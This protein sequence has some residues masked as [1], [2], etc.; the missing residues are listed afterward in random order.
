[1]DHFACF[2]DV[3]SSIREVQTGQKR[4][5][6]LSSFARFR[7]SFLIHI[8]LAI[9]PSHSFGYTLFS[10]HNAVVPSSFDRLFGGGICQP[11]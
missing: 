4:R 10:G 1:M 8:L 9:L 3:C 2:Q 7:S 5:H 6:S 11:V